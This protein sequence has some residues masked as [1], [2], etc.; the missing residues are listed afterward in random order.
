MF[1]ANDKHNQQSFID[2][3]DWMD[4]RVQKKLEKSW[5]PIFY[6]HVFKQIDEMPFRVLFGTTGNPN[7]PV[8][9][10]LSLEYIKHM[11]CCND[12][13]LIDY[14]NFDYLV[15][16]AVG[17]RVLGALN[18][19]ERTI[20]NFRERLYRYCV[21]HPDD[22]D[23]L[24]NQFISLLHDFADKANISLGEQRTDTTMFMS[25]IK[26]SG[27]ISL[28]YDVLVKAV[29]AIPVEKLNEKLSN[30]LKPDFKTETLYRTRSTEGESKLSIL[31]N[32]C[33]E[34][35]TILE[36]DPVLC[37]SAEARITAR[38]INEQ[39]MAE[40]NDGKLVPKPNKEISSDSLQSAFDENATFRKKGKISQS[41]YVL[42]ISET[43]S[44]DNVFQLITD[45]VV[46]P[47]IKSDVDILTERLPEIKINT[48]CTDMYVDG[49]FHS[50]EVNEIAQTNDIN[51]HLTNMSGKE[52]T[53]KMPVTEFQIEEDS[54][55]ILSCPSGYIPTQYG[56][57]KG[58]TTAHFPHGTCDNCDLFECCHSKKQ[59]KDYVV[60]INLKALDTSRI[61]ESIKKNIKE[62]T[63]KRA[64][65]EGSNSALKRMGH[66]KLDVRGDTKC[67]FVS[68]IK[69]TVQNIK[70]FIKYKQGGYLPKNVNRTQP[71]VIAPI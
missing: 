50:D 67:S 28:A 49:G 1:K 61:R 34:A 60:R 18:L 44:K 69:I 6:E 29:K 12:L 47:N 33:K 5:A 71:G 16:Y 37:D 42:E 31:L 57:S 59:V 9:I 45:S 54:N 19:C 4:P 55:I 48:G 24:F 64:A 40:L 41:G 51:I 39:S 22:E 30:V 56:L 11:K 2:T 36:T 13:E 62:N 7:F 35:L 15:N 52:P 26:K 8:N 20:Y 32:L 68:R 27:R 65:I 38:F 63:S 43:C 3:F 46:E 17:N 21:E 25:N 70:R 66:D 10:L 53:V 14:Y 23:I 58:Q